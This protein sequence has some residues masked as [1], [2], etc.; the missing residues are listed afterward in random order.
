MRVFNKRVK[1]IKLHLLTCE[2]ETVT[3]LGHK[4]GEVNVLVKDQVPLCQTRE[5]RG[6]V[7]VEFILWLMEPKRLYGF[8]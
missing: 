2:F 6:Y 4:S 5:L 7:R 8:Y 3:T 1:V